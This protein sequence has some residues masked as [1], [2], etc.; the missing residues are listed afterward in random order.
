MALTK[1]CHAAKGLSGRGLPTARALI[2]MAG[3]LLAVSCASGDA[4]EPPPVLP[5]PPGG[6]TARPPAAPVTPP[7]EPPAPPLGGEPTPAPPP[8]T[9]ENPPAPPAPAPPVIDPGPAPAPALGMFSNPAAVKLPSFPD[10]TCPV[11]A[12]A[13]TAAI[14]AAI[15]SCSNQGGGVVSFAPGTYSIGS[16]HLKSNV[17]LQLNGATLRAGGGIDPPERYTTP[18][19]CQD[20]GHSHWH[21]ALLWGEDLTNIAIVGP[22]TLDGRGLDMELQKMIALKSSSVMLFEGFSQVNTGHFAYLLTDC[23]HITMARLNIRPTRDGVDLMECTNVNA[24]DLNI[25]GGPDDAFALKNDCALGKP[26]PTDNVTVRDSTFS[27]S[28][29]NAVQI[30]S[31]TWGD[32]QNIS[33]SNI[34]ITGGAKSGI[35]IQMNDGAVIRNVSYENV[36][37]TNTSFPIFISTTSL[38]RGPTRTPGHAENLRFRNIT[39]TGIVTG[40]GPNPQ[41]T[42][43]VISGQSAALHQ[44][45]VLEDV[46]ITFPGG[47]NR[48]GHPPEGDTLR[49][50]FAYNPRFI[51]PLPAYGLYVRHV[52][53]LQ[54]RNVQLD[55]RADDQRPAVIARNVEGLTLEAFGARRAGGPTL[56]LETVKNLTIQRSAPLPDSMIPVVERM[57][58]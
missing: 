23:H 24:H 50:E 11:A 18:I 2:S 19:R 26:L 5:P 58:F 47:G 28:I 51:S 35:G 6:G 27:A 34:K 42:A 14:N 52:K 56:E 13:N 12:G 20:E 25:T 53:G 22:G 15:E 3:L 4:P 45:I 36:T 41:N 55:F 43:V 17:K 46:K 7:A 40:N 33:W 16:I 21:N 39:A 9:P 10:R 29:A 30:G 49:G 54:L 37:M 38:L 48:S 1:V 32:F 44:G 31:E 8:A 57:A